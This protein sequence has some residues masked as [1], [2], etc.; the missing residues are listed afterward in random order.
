V[1]GVSMLAGFVLYT[2]MIK[3]RLYREVS[4]TRAG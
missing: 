1:T 2:L 3:R 4:V